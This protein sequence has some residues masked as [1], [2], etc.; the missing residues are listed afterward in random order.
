MFD[1]NKAKEKVQLR[2]GDIL[3]VYNSIRIPEE[4]QPDIVFPESTYNSKVSSAYNT[5]QTS[6]A[7]TNPN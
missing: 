6:K 2:I 3:V 4:L 1:R 7:D 5:N